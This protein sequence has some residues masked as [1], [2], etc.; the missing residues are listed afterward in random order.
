MAQPDPGPRKAGAAPGAAAR[1][2]WVWWLCTGLILVAAGVVALSRRRELVEAYHLITRVRLPG[3]VAA[4]ALESMSVLCFAAVPHWLLQT[5]GSR[6]SMRRMACTTMAGNAMAGALPGGAAFSAAWM[7]RYLSRRGAGQA[8]AAAVL[9]TAGALSVFSLFLLLVT[10]VLVAGPSGPDVYVRPVV[11]ALVLALA[12]GLVILGLSRFAG[13]RRV[14]RRAWAST[15]RHSRRVVNAE[16]ALIRLTEQVRE[17][18]PRLLPWLRPF[19]FAVLNWVL[20]AA[21]LAAGMWAL[22]IG[23]PWHGLLFAYA[24]TQIASTLRLTPG[25][26]VITEATL[27]VLLAVY[28]LQPGQAIAATFFY[29]IIGF[30]AL[31]P[32]GWAC[33]T[34]LTLEASLADRKRRSR[35]RWLRRGAAGFTR[36]AGRLSGPPRRYRLRKPR[37][38]LP[39]CRGRRCG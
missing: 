6:W 21:C 2:G 36:R 16:D 37:R 32:V 27:S 28:G 10:G 19:A 5:G 1:P 15:G 22:G 4:V 38:R 9:V 3:L 26:L 12:F 17:V 8:L 7:F 35:A 13:F 25:N 24:L 31:Q 34:G 23:V 20:D 39:S 18:Q 33:W 11:G 29:R 30:W 14:L